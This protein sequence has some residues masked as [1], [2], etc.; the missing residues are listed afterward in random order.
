ML[1]IL[2]CVWNTYLKDANFKI[3]LLKTMATHLC[4]KLRIPK[5]KHVACTMQD[6][7]YIIFYNSMLYIVY[8]IR[9]TIDGVLYV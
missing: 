3:M 9:C 2:Y 8:Y 5:G 4:I 7:L 6:S 1:Y